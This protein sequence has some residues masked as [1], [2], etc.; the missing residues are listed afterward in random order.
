MQ[1]GLGT[2]I[3]VDHRTVQIYFAAVDETRTYAQQSAPLTRVRFAIN[4]S[5]STASA[6][7]IT[8]SSISESDGLLIYQGIDQDGAQVSIVETDLD[9]SMRLSRPADRLLA[10]IIDKPKWYELRVLTRNLFN[11]ASCSETYGLIGARTNL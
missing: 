5:I 7:T 9:H 2:V 8:V 1:F 4:D 3:N 6:S 10:G 11:Q